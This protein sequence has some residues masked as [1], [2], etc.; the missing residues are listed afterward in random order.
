V[1]YFTEISGRV[2]LHMEGGPVLRARLEG[3]ELTADGEN[4]YVTIEKNG[5]RII[6]KKYNYIEV[7]GL[8]NTIHSFVFSNL[9]GGYSIFDVEFEGRLAIVKE[10]PASSS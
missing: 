10:E 5:S 1:E 4:V 8:V 7:K 9:E 6:F 2:A 3:K